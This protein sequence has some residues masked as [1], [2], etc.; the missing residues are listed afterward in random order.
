MDDFY[1]SIARSATVEI[2]VKGSRFIAEA[3]AAESAEDAREILKSIRK[4]GHAATHHC[5]AYRIGRADKQE[6]KYSDDGE[7]SGTAGKPIYECLSGREL[8]NTIVVVTRYFGGTKLGTGGLAR[9]YVDAAKQ[10][11][12]KAGK[13]TTFITDPLNLQFDLKYYDQVVKLLS[14]FSAE[15][16]KSD[17]SEMAQLKVAIRKS[18]TKELIETLT[19]LTNGQ[20]KISTK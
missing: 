16:I 17:F 4:K 18:K 15:Q 9:A 20:I 10:A 1:Y 11:L 8:T 14:K 12:E 19:N 7:P 2:K 5:Y 6:F 13:K 3:K